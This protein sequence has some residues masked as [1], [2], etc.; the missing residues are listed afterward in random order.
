[1]DIEAMTGNIRIVG[2]HSRGNKLLERLAIER[3]RFD[4]RVQSLAREIYDSGDGALILLCDPS[5]SRVV[6]ERQFRL[7]GF[8]F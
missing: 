2:R 3:K 7:P 5:R 1:L 6:L 8:F 4:G